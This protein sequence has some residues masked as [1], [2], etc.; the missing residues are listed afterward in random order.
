MN[1]TNYARKSAEYLRIS[2]KSCNFA[3]KISF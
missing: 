3:A 1:Y 2:E